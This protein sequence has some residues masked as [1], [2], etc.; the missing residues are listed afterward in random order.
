MGFYTILSA[1]IQGIKV[2]MIQ[3]EVDVGNGLPVFHMVGFLA[4]EVKEAAERVRTALK[5][6][7]FMIPARKV[8]VN[9]SPANV[10]KRGTA[11]D[12]PI[13]LG[14][15]MALQILPGNRQKNALVV[16]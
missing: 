12:L 1:S 14:V 5:N 13:A 11:F 10:R 7:G 6:T 15:L 4:S 16:G 8:V 3:V 2:E 9:L